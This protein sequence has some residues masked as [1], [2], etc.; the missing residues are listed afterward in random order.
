MWVGTTV[1]LC[2]TLLFPI[3]YFIYNGII[4]LLTIWKRDAAVR[5]FPLER[6]H[7]LFGTIPFVSTHTLTPITLLV[8]HLTNAQ[9]CKTPKEMSV[10][11]A[12]GYS[13][14]STRREIYNKYQYDSV[15]MTFKSRCV[16]GLWTKV[17][18]VFE[19]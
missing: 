9:L 10:T 19:G 7:W 8:A 11:L 14:E 3:V 18:S 17:A 1:A 2:T 6:N 16:L 13:S 12:N 15:S 4:S 5:K